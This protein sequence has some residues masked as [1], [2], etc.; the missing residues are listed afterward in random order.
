[1]GL[2]EFDAKIWNYI[3]NYRH[4]RVIKLGVPKNLGF[5]FVTGQT[6]L[7]PQ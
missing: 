1:M 5:N 3:D 6:A 2:K 7:Q 4:T